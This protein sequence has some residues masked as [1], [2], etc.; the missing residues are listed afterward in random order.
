MKFAILAG[1]R[2]TRLSELTQNMN[3][4]LIEI[5]E[6]PIVMHISV[7]FFLAGVE[8]ISLLIGFDSNKFIERFELARIRILKT[9]TAPSVIKQMLKTIN[10]SFLDAGADADTFERIRGVSASEPVMVT[11]GDTLTNIDVRKVLDFWKSKD[12][13][14]ALTC[15]VRPPKRFSSIVWNESSSRAVSFEEKIGFESSYVGCGFI[16]LSSECLHSISQSAKSLE[17]DVLPWLAGKEKLLVY[18]H[19]GCW[20]PIDYLNDLDEAKKIWSAT[21]QNEVKWI[22]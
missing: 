19:T 11:Y 3:K 9:E 14:S 7:R 8:E 22:S 20:I 2:G 21:N 15:I 17:R 5:G 13:S 6:I 12:A 10:F 18:E 4:P 16:I 1:G